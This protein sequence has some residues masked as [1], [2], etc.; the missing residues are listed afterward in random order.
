MFR[1]KFL[2]FC[3]L[4]SSILFSCSQTSAELGLDP[5]L[6]PTFLDDDDLVDAALPE[7][8]QTLSLNAQETVEDDPSSPFVQKVSF[9]GLMRGMT[10]NLDEYVEAKPNAAGEAQSFK[11]YVLNGEET[12]SAGYIVNGNG[13]S[14]QLVLTEPGPVYLNLVRD[15]GE[16]QTYVIQVSESYAFTDFQT[17][18]RGVD[19]NYQLKHYSVSGNARD[20]VLDGYRGRNW[21][22][23]ATSQTGMLLSTLDD[24][25]YEFNLASVDG[26][27]DVEVPPISTK[28]AWYNLFVDLSSF[29]DS[30]SWQTTKMFETN[31]RL[32]KYNLMF[33]GTSNEVSSFFSCLYYLNTYYQN[34]STYYYPYTI[35][36]S[37]QNGNLAF[38]PVVANQSLTALAVLP[39]VEI[40]AAGQVKINTLDNYITDQLAPAKADVSELL[41]NLDY[42]TDVFDYTVSCDSKVLDSQGNEVPRSNPY[43]S[44]YFSNLY[45]S[46]WHY[47]TETTY[48]DDNFHGIY[49]EIEPGGLYTK[50]NRTFEFVD[51]DGNGSCETVYE[52]IQA[53]Q[54][55]SS[56]VW[57]GYDNI[58][59]F[60]TGYAYPSSSVRNGYA[61]YDAEAH[62]YTFTGALA[63]GEDLIEG[64]LVFGYTANI[65][66]N[67][68]ISSLIGT[69]YAK[70]MFSFEYDENGKLTTFTNVITITYPQSLLTVLDHD[71]TWRLEITVDDIGK[72]EPKAQQILEENDVIAKVDA[73]LGL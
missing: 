16:T 60:L 64:G 55:T 5:S 66:N 46:P 1:K 4:A 27:V 70:S 44:A 6:A 7:G 63:A 58:N 59:G 24:S 11:A 37:Y 30:D 57:W 51:M 65:I 22:Y 61:Q 12:A 40:S 8:S 25:I 19:D 43:V 68:T 39:E 21:I 73:L 38:L 52:Y 62:T 26:D 48:Y 42:L 69:D 18:L 28:A 71:Y 45:Y 49:P 14:H 53:G 2:P 47:V 20:L 50:N 67:S 13:M 29:A 10:V 3:L 56:P 9:D 35:L 36:G 32:S 54:Q 31:T 23:D 72:T 41:D 15:D 17:A 34:G 33:T